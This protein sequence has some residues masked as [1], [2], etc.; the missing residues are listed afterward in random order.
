MRP[1]LKL[2]SNH[3]VVQPE[4]KIVTTITETVCVIIRIL[5]VLVDYNT[6]FQLL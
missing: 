4:R 1:V 6:M 5:Y 3:E 2:S